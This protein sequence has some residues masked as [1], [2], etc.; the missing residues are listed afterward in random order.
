MTR[1]TDKVAE[2]VRNYEFRGESDYTPTDDERALIE[3]AIQG[4]I[5]DHVAPDPIANAAMPGG[6]AG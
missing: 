3:D 1:L 4:F 2:Y 6:V 5:A